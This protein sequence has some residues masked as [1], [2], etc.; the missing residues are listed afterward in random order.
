MQMRKI[1]AK[2]KLFI[3][4]YLH[5]LVLSQ[6]DKNT[7]HFFEDDSKRDEYSLL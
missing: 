2:V 6:I 1:L 4:K 7:C 3:H 5:P